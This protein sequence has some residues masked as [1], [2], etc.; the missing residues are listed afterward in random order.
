MFSPAIGVNEDP[1]TGNANCALGAYL[2]YHNLVAHN[3]RLLRFSSLQ[4]RTGH[5]PGI[6][7]VEVDIQNGQPVCVRVGDQAVIVG[8]RIFSI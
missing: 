4:G 8:K 2:V 3:G 6:V 5:R 1:V 7:R